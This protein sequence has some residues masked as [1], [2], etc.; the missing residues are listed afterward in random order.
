MEPLSFSPTERASQQGPGLGHYLG[1]LVDLGDVLL[2]AVDIQSNSGPCTP[3][4]TQ[5]KDDAG[6][7]C[8]KEPQA[9]EKINRDHFPH[10]LDGRLKASKLQ[11]VPLETN[12]IYT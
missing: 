7:I 9:L 6:T 1:V 2:I 5:S 10:L 8:K 3:S 11:G 12:R 4:A